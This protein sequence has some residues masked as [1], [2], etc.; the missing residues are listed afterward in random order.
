LKKITKIR[1][2]GSFSVLLLVVSAIAAVARQNPSGDW[3][4]WGR[5]PGQSRFSP[6]T[7][8]TPENV[9]RLKPVWVY[10]PSAR[11][12]SWETTPIVVQNVMYFETRSSAVAVDPETGKE[13]WKF[14]P[15]LGNHQGKGV[16]YWPGDD[17]FGPRILYAI[18]DRLYALDA[19]TGKPISSFADNG[20]V[21]LRTGVAE[22]FPKGQYTISAPPA[23]YKNLAIV[24]PSTQEFGST[25][26]SGDPRA[27]DIT[28]GH[29]V[30]R[31]HTVPQPGEPN[32]D[33]W[34]PNGYKDRAGPSAWGIASVDVERGMVFIPIGNPD[35][36]F[37]G[38]DRPGKNLYANS[39]VA[40]DAAT[41][42]LIWYYQLTHHDLSD[43]D[44]AAAPAL[45][46]V[47]RKGKKI[48]AVVEISKP[49]LM[50]ILD[51]LTGKPIFGDEERPVPQSDVP[52]ESYYPTQPF[53]IK[54]PPLV[55]MSMTRADI[56][57]LTP[58][59]N[60]F[61][62][63]LWDQNEMHNDGVYS[64]VSMKGT[65]VEV[66]GSIGGADWGGVSFDEKL[67]FIFVNVSNN[68]IFHKMVPDGS[69]G[70]KLVGSYTRYL[71]QKSYPCIQPPWGE[72]VAINANTGDIAW[73][74][75]L[76][77]ADEYGPAGA[78]TGTPNLGGSIATASGL[79]FIG[80]TTDSRFRAFDSRTG[81]E[82]WTMPIPASAVSS[83]M[84]FIGRSGR[85][86]VVTA[87]GGPGL[88]KKGSAAYKQ[89]LIAFAIP[90]AG[91]Q[92]VDLAV[93]A[94][95]P[96][97]VMNQQVP[98]PAP[99]ANTPA[100]VHPAELP[101]GAGRE[102]VLSMCTSCHDVTTAVSAR[103][104]PQEWTD[105]IEVM[106][107]RGALGDDAMAARVQRYLSQ[108]FGP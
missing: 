50:F 25:G 91:E 37:N 60:K 7:E 21:N 71:D 5:D 6:L 104:T 106:R 19:K 62:T 1:H 81:K 22:K 43:Y 57:A 12:A 74:S 92:P 53:P 33:S 96:A 51:R 38:I 27:F 2:I 103:R 48:P 15:D 30:W 23:I 70:Y 18:A 87:A 108:H 44:V 45:I 46:D 73:R 75:P 34:G 41:G 40:L 97:P 89:V 24:S 17:R 13:I 66:P 36:S 11:G 32:S 80:A 8:I 10:D 3:T 78:K 76:G 16:S 107:G 99:P 77:A 90:R 54:P 100:A 101:P 35:D 79:V 14:S 4:T 9:N 56:S 63:S 58:E 20:S 39:L 88:A 61:C 83:P 59:A 105:I 47:I 28:T 42:K 95:A 98:V 31:F 65:T 52:G 86:Y 82:I 29:M 55:P 93:Y 85:Q 67:G 72:L 94:T 102:D 84:T 69:G 26:P 64:P 68:P 49:G